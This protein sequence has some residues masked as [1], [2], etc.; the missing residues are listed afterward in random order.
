MRDSRNGLQLPPLPGPGG[1]GTVWAVAMVKNEVDI[2]GDTLDHLHRQ[3]VDGILVSDN[4]S[5]DGTYEL[6][7]DLAATMPLHIARD[8]LVA[9]HQPEKMTLLSH[10]ARRAGAEWIV[11]FDADEFWFA[12]GRTVA[13]ELRGRDRTV[14]VVEAWMHNVFPSV[15]G[16]MF[17]LTPARLRKVAFRAHRLARLDVG[18]HAVTHP[19]KHGSG[20]YL[21][22]YPWRS[23]E[24]FEAK[25]RQGSLALTREFRRHGYGHHWD[26]VASADDAWLDSAWEDLLHGRTH[27][28][29]GWQVEGPLRA[30]DPRRWST[31][32]GA[33]LGARPGGRRQG[34]T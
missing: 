1:S 29:F 15:E 26:D 24:Q 33:E 31:W 27:R 23:R 19:G 18:N 34:S 3:G 14:G 7:Q 21:A 30:A 2:I 20:L 17:D 25:A 13:A 11:P 28:E 5:T 4:L 22:H 32:R 12:V 10:W 16:W 6:L 9:Y 8:N